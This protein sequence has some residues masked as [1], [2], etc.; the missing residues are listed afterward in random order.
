VTAIALLQFSRA[1]L[2]LLFVLSRWFYPNADLDSRVDIKVLVYFVS[3]HNASS[4]LL[5]LS[6]AFIVAIGSGLWRLKQWA[7]IALMTTSGMTVFLW[8]RWFALDWA[9]PSNILRKGAERQTILAVILIDS[10]IYCCLAFYPGVAR[11][12]GERV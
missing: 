10:L 8:I 4:I 6:A 5:P 1:G 12:F 2:I 11:S 7:R 9:M 3:R